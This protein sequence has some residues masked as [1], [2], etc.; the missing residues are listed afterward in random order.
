MSSE[1]KFCIKSKHFSV[2]IICTSGV[3]L[4]HII[5]D[6]QEPKGAPKTG[7][8]DRSPEPGA[9]T[10]AR[11]LGPDGPKP[12]NDINVEDKIRQKD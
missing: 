1:L 11:R 9:R 7:A 12:R 8:G 2:S 5:S 3:N 4:V 10:E 6:L